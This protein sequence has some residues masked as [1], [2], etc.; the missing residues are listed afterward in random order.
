MSEAMRATRGRIFEVQ[1]FCIHDG[2][3]IRTTVFLKGCP[4]R[5]QW[6]H[7]PEGASV[8]RHLSFIAE[9]CIGCGYCFRVC[10]RGAHRMMDGR[11]ELDRA[12]CEACGSCTEECYAGALEMVGRDATAGEVIDEV[13]RDRPFYETSGGGMTLSGGEPLFQIDFTEA[14]LRLAKASGLGCVIET[15]GY[16]D[17]QSFERVLPLTDLFFYDIKEMTPARHLEFTGVSNARILDNLR[18]LHEAGARI[19]LRCPIIPGYNDRDDHFDAL[20]ALA[21]QL[22]GIDGVELMP[23]HPLGESKVVR[24]GIDGAVRARSQ[25]PAP[26]AV[27]GWILRLRAQSVKVLNETP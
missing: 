15:C 14:L 25:S 17:F 24:F 27:R 5:C 7:N 8:E 20:A 4:L 22:P 26:E 9:R 1:R 11:H 18:A 2:P 3:G 13:L 16:A 10:P 23:Y 19:R 6:C 12:V 21:R